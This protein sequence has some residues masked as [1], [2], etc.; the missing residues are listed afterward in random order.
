MRKNSRILHQISSSKSAIYNVS[1]PESLRNTQGRHR[2]AVG[3]FISW[4]EEN[5]VLHSSRYLILL[6]YS[7]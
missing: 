3:Y 5:R 1:K 2:V 6:K 4:N 7:I